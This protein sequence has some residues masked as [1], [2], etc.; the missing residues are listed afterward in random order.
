MRVQEARPQCWSWSGPGVQVGGR[1]METL[2]VT[3]VPN[4]GLGT[5]LMLENTAEPMK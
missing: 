3:P 4:T 5:C 2:C 1:L